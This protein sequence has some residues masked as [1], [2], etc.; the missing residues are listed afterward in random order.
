MVGNDALTKASFS[1][2]VHLCIFLPMKGRIGTSRT[3]RGENMAN[4][5]VQKKTD[6]DLATEAE[7]LFKRSRKL[8]F[9][10]ALITYTR[11]HTFAWLT[12]VDLR[13]AFPTIMRMGWYKSRADLRMAVVHEI[14]GLFPGK[15]LYGM[16]LEL[17][18]NNIDAY[19]DA[20]DA[21]PE[22]WDFAFKPEH[23]VV[24]GKPEMYW[25]LF[26]NRL[27]PESNDDAHK[28]L[29]VFIVEQALAVVDGLEPI[30]T[31][32]DVLNAFPPELLEEKLP[33]DKRS[34][35]R[36]ERLA[37]Q[38]AKPPKVYTAKNEY[39]DIGG[40]KML[41]EC[42]NLCEFKELL[43][44]IEGALGFIRP[45]KTEAEV[46]PESAKPN[47]K[48]TVAPAPMSNDGPQSDGQP[49]KPVASKPPPLPSKSTPSMRAIVPT[50]LRAEDDE[51]DPVFADQ[52]PESSDPKGQA[53]R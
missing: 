17:Q 53:G 35:S 8:Q 46:P 38:T 28:A 13:T 44:T 24:L 41:V 30:I 31:E 11:E 26:R 21:T 6:Q 2:N 52:K 36:K 4:P 43:N 18:T 33:L 22:K 3:V 23:I 1:A 29:F 32:V 50:D 16:L 20:G 15:A 39:L 10:A 48:P 25:F 37:F 19:V 9:M 40:V 47:D 51:L 42:I 12:A 27:P 7:K 45:P 14:T 5:L 34:A 49:P